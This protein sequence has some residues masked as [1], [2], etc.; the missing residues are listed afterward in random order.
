VKSGILLDLPVRAFNNKQTNKQTE[1]ERKC[2]YRKGSEALV[3]QTTKREKCRNNKTSSK[4][5]S[6]D[7]IG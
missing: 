3:V 7:F 4:R 1:R 2:E 6:A 5:R